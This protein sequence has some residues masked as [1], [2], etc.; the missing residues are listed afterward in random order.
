MLVWHTARQTNAP[1]GSTDSA[2][3]PSRILK[4]VFA[5]YDYWLGGVAVGADRLM[6]DDL[7]V[8][9][10]AGQSNAG[11]DMDNNTGKGKIDS[12]F[13]SL[14]GSYFTDRMYFDTTISYGRQ[15]YENT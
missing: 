4:T 13:G 1:Y 6:E 7:L 11:V 3:G 9:I 2:T 14:Y 12:Y 15:R 5:G 10:S 8:G